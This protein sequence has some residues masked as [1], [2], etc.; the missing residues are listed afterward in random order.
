MIF[1]NVQRVVRK[2]LPAPA[3]ELV[4]ATS[5]A[6]LT[7]FLFSWSSGHFVSSLRRKAIDGHGEALPW[8][9]YPAIELLKSKDFSTCRV[10]E[11]GAGQSTVW[12][13]QRA[14]SVVSVESNSDWYQRVKAEAPANVEL[15]HAD[16]ELRTFDFS[17]IAA[18]RFD[19]VIVDGLD[20]YRA[21]ELGEGVLSPGG[22]LLVD[23]S[24][25][26]AGSD[27]DYP[28]TTRLRALGYSRV[29]FYGHAPG[30]I[31]PHCTSFFFRGECFL[32][33]GQENPRVLAG[34]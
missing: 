25:S 11:F 22:C 13:S 16:R 23:N 17:R 9:T 7:P 10:L 27:G 18:Q 30:V 26:Y 14:L 4:R 15:H 12:W 5:T 6:L 32:F 33:H 24:D 21:A 8:Y 31:L 20:R 34:S 1:Q 28:I 2:V 19:V 3:A 29:D